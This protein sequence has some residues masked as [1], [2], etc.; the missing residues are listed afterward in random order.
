MEEAFLNAVL[1]AAQVQGLQLQA[2]CGSLKRAG[3]NMAF[4]AAKSVY[5]SGLYNLT[6]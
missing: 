5:I 6:G 1:D 4:E 3:R 2:G